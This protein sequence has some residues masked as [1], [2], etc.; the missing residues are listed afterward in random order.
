M[1]SMARVSLP[2]QCSAVIVGVAAFMLSACSNSA[3]QPAPSPVEVSVVQVA[4]GAQP[5][6]LAYS[7]RTRGIREVEVRARVSG[8]LERRYYRQ[9]DRVR[10]GDPMFR[11]DPLPSAATVRSA[12][13]RLGVESARLKE[14]KLRHDRVTRLHDHGFATGAN[15]D[16]ADADYAAAQSAVASARA[17]LDRARLDLSF[18]Q[19]R[20]PISGITGTETRSEG[21]LVDATLAESSLLTTITQTDSLY[22]DFSM[23]EQEARA[24]RTLMD[25]GKVFVHLT[26][27]GSGAIIG[28]APVTF[29]DSRVGM[30]TGTVDIRATLDNR[31]GR[32]SPGQFVRAEIADLKAPGGVYVPA[33]AISH[34]TDGPFVWKIDA[35]NVA[36][37]QPV[38]LGTPVGNFIAVTKGLAPGERVVV[39]GILKLQPGMTV[40]AVRVE[41]GRSGALE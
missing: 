5:V 27:S 39:E 16:L 9:G 26:A 25:R 32:L 31:D 15:R 11:I 14:A 8:I 37:M 2:L 4:A 33:R 38:T 40:R 29:V 30:D 23:P 35:K 18:T 7:A 41:P 22:I 28:T 1:A 34:G 24:V 21:S 13:G 36:R 6:H 10:A 17:D 19:V 3:E 12:Q 20:A